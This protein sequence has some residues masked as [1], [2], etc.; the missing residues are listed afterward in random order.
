MEQYTHINVD[1]VAKIQKRIAIA[2]S[3]RAQLKAILEGEVDVVVDQPLDTAKIVVKPKA[4]ATARAY[5]TMGVR[6][7][8]KLCEE[9]KIF[10]SRM[11]KANMVKALNDYDDI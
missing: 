7:L 2:E 4:P 8:K 10:K 6:D 9:R 3:D 11:V 1:L 5:D